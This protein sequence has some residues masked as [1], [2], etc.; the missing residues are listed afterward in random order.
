MCV[1]HFPGQDYQAKILTNSAVLWETKK[2]DIWL[3]ILCVNLAVYIE[4]IIDYQA[5]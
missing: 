5:L 1:L 3:D 4:L 2:G